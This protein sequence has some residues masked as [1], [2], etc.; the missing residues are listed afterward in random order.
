MSSSQRDSLC[1]ADLMLVHGKEH[2]VD[3]T[4]FR[5]R[6]VSLFCGIGVYSIEF[7]SGGGLIEETVARLGRALVLTEEEDEGVTISPGTWLGKVGSDGFYLV[8]RILSTRVY[9]LEF[10]R[11]TLKAAMNPVKGMEISKIGEGRLLFKFHHRLDKSRVWER[12][13]WMFDKNLLVLNDV[14]DDE[15]PLIVPLNWS[16]FH[17]HVHGLPVKQMTKEMAEAIGHRLGKY[18][19]SADSCQFMWGSSMRLRVALDI[20]KPLK[21]FLRLRTVRGEGSIVSF[22]YERLPNFCYLC[23]LL[24]HI[25]RNCERRYEDGFVNPGEELQYGEWLRAPTYRSIIR[26]G[27]G[28]ANSWMEF[29]RRPEADSTGSDG[30]HNRRRGIN[31]FDPSPNKSA[32][33]QQNRGVDDIVSPRIQGGGNQGFTE[34]KSSP[35]RV[36]NLTSDSGVGHGLSLNSHNSSQPHYPSPVILSPPTHITPISSNQNTNRSQAQVTDTSP[37]VM[38]ILNSPHTHVTS[39]NSSQTQVSDTHMMH[40]EPNS[41]Y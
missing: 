23:G 6:R 16:F 20:S 18:E 37:K 26:Q 31:I 19:D 10:V 29:A 4:V 21:R 13:P 40:P 22:T 41:T 28:L 27:E 8:G 39:T 35:N 24:G 3:P 11:T 30:G 32:V 33:E 2:L 5:G 9:R 34:L 38:N 15:N 14:V 17:I 36:T 25:D 12:S 7:G 1:S